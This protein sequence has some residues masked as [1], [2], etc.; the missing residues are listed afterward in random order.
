MIIH[1][2]TKQRFE[3]RKDC[4]IALGGHLEFNNALKNGEL[5]FVNTHEANDIIIK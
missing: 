4:K 2:P 3:N 5:V 1:L